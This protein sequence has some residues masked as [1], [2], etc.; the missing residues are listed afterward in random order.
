LFEGR[1]DASGG[2][3]GHHRVE[4]DKEKIDVFL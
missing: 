4:G 3:R 1:N 2:E